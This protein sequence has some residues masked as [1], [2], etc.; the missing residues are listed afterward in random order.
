MKRNLYLMFALLL[1][2][3]AGGQSPQVRVF[4]DRDG[5]PS[6]EIYTLSFDRNGY[7]MLGSEIGTFRFNGKDFHTYKSERLNGQSLTG[8]CESR[9]GAFASTFNGDIAEFVGDSIIPLPNAGKLLHSGYHSL[10]SDGLNLWAGT[11]MGLFLLRKYPDGWIDKSPAVLK[12]Y[13][14]PSVKGLIRYRNEIWATSMGT[15]LQIKGESVR[16]IP[17]EFATSIDTSILRYFVAPGPTGTWLI[18]YDKAKAYHLENDTF[19]KYDKPGLIKA[20]AGKKFTRVVQSRNALILLSYNGLMVYYPHLDKAVWYF[21]GTPF[22]DW[23]EDPEGHTWLSTMGYGLYFIPNFSIITYNRPGKNDAFDKVLRLVS[24]GKGGIYMS[25]LSGVLGHLP[26]GTSTIE[27]IPV[28]VQSDITYLRRQP[29]GEIYFALNDK[30]FAVNGNTPRYIVKNPSF[31]IKDFI[32]G[33]KFYY[34]ASSTGLFYGKTNG[35]DFASKSKLAIGWVRRIA[36]DVKSN[37]IWAASNRGLYHIKDTVVDTS[38]FKNEVVNELEWDSVNRTLY[39]YVLSGKLYAIRDG[40]VKSLPLFDDK[41]IQILKIRHYNSQLYLGTSAG[42]YILHLTDGG[43]RWINLQDGLASN[44]IYDILILNNHLWLA[45]GSG[46]QKLPLDVPK[47]ITYPNLIP[48]SQRIGEENVPNSMNIRM[49]SRQSL[50]LIFDVISYYSNGDFYLEYRFNREPWQPLQQGQTQLFLNGIKTDA[51]L[52]EVRV[53]DKSGHHSPSLLYELVISPPYWQSPWF[54]IALVFFTLVLV[55]AGFTIYI[56]QERSQQKNRV[57][58]MQLE[59]SL[60]ESQL[61]ALKAQMNP[62]FIFNSLNS[63]YELI[64]FNETKDA[65]AYL[66]KFAILLRKVLENSEKET[67]NLME[68]CDWLELY[69]QLE[70]LR[71]G[72]D[73]SY[74]I[75]LQEVHDPYNITVPTMLLQPFVENAVKHGL[76]HKEGIK[77]LEVSFREESDELICIITDNGVGR[78]EAEEFN[79]K[80]PNK[81]KSFATGAIVQRIEML[82]RKGSGKIHFAIEDLYFPDGS[83]AGTQVE[84]TI[85]LT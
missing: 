16:C 4:T 20:M 9:Y 38:Y 36:G 81:Y 8:Y 64:V 61:K 75:D 79:S 11:D 30:L 34:L 6:N 47:R 27:S 69:L 55:T 19:R 71:F 50:N 78:K 77:R 74:E 58:K 31:S 84:M 5:L 76:L 68:E 22:T 10:V 14:T 15:V 52:L 57:E 12:Q 67:I 18:H 44:V 33:P 48:L 39:A 85:P 26:A 3:T 41:S 29:N 21:E 56:S 40:Q 7:L 1:A 49:S 13:K 62:H 37:D 51:K 63:I 42:L 45:T 72:Q 24:D 73:F 25:K 66:N 60:I 83:S 65:A 43:S 53:T 2:F 35:Y 46:L 23:R 82:N 59:T 70:K 80:R 17:I 28:G 54:Y 32:I